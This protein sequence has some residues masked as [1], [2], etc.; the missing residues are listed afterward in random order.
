MRRL[1]IILSV[2]F[3]MSVLPNSLDDAIVRGIATEDDR[4]DNS[5]CDW[6]HPI[7]L[8]G[9]IYIESYEEALADPRVQEILRNA[10]ESIGQVETEQQTIASL[11]A[12][13]IKWRA[14]AQFLEAAVK[15]YAEHVWNDIE[16]RLSGVTHE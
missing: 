3:A 2:V 7:P 15:Q 9:V 10:A 16:Q 14:R 11:S 8:V 1:V 13:V 5:D 6:C 12:S 4:C